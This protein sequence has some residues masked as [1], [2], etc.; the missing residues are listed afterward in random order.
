MYYDLNYNQTCVRYIVNN[1]IYGEM[2]VHIGYSEWYCIVC[3][4][5]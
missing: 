3:V 2:D 5:S 1:I 4:A